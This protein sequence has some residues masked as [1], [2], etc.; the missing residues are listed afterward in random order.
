ME[1]DR[2]VITL[3]VGQRLTV[4][5]AVNWTAPRAVA[6][7]SV[8]APLQPL[9]LDSAVGFP[10]MVPASATFTAVRT[11]SASVSAHT[12]YACL[13]SKPACLPAQHTFS[14]AVQVLPAPGG[15][16]GPQPVPGSY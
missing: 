8:T 15:R 3:H 16:A 13:H 4:T 12:D 5:L 10:A 7:P 11:G 9:R 14:V 1:T 2:R 6:G